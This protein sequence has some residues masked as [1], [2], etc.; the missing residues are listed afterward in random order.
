MKKRTKKTI[1]IAVK[2]FTRLLL[3]TVICAVLWISMEVISFAIFKKEV[4]YQ[5]FDL[6]NMSAEPVTHYYQAGE[7]IQTA[8]SLNVDPQGFI[9]I[10]KVPAGANSIMRTITQIMMLILYCIFPHHILWEFGNRDD[11]N[12]R[13]RGQKPDPYRG[14]KIG[15]IA[16]IPTFLAWFIL[17]IS[18]FVPILSNYLGFYRVL[19]LP[20]F[21]YNDWV[22]GGATA[23]ADI[24]V[25]Q[26]LLLIPV[27]LIVPLVCAVAYRMGHNQFSISEFLTFT[28]KKNVTI[29]QDEE[30]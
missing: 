8:E 16:M 22:F 28:K 27:F 20:Y 14:L 6:D 25:W 19:M 11:T 23:I 10:W 4:G 17:V 7:A 18:K 5:I 29:E 24:A 26:L 12:V 2:V 15:F 9:P 21:Y 1:R 13:Y 3:A 30:I